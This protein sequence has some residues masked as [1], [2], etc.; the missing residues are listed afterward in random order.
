MYVTFRIAQTG[1]FPSSGLPE[2]SAPFGKLAWFS[3]F[4]KRVRGVIRFG[5]IESAVSETTYFSFNTAA[6]QA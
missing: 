2:D 5:P 6:G 4:F 3:C 1:I